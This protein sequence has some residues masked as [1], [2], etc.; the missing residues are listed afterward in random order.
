MLERNLSPLLHFSPLLH[1]FFTYTTKLIGRNSSDDLSIKCFSP[2]IDYQSILTELSLY[3]LLSHRL[4]LSDAKVCHRTLSSR[5]E[6]HFLQNLPPL[7]SIQ[8]EKPADKFNR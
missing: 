2:F 3:F 6:M 8:Q 1:T 4:V 5:F 7:E